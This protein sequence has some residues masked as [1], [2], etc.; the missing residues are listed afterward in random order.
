M[1]TKIKYRYQ[2]LACSAVTTMLYLSFIPVAVSQSAELYIKAEMGDCTKTRLIVRLDGVKPLPNEIHFTIKTYERN[3][4]DGE[5]ILNQQRLILTSDRYI[6][7]GLLP[8]GRYSAQAYNKDKRKLSDE[9]VFSN[10]RLVQI[11]DRGGQSEIVQLR[12]GDVTDQE[13]IS[14][15]SKIAQLSLDRISYSATTRRMHLILINNKGELADQY[16]GPPVQSWKSKPLPIGAYKRIMVEYDE[17]Y[18]CK[19]IKILN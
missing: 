16:L 13:N 2:L 19:P 18:S 9:Y 7:I 6:W 3:S 5:V 11:L 12:G 15:G 8:L 17:A 14:S 4:Q 1:E 10:E